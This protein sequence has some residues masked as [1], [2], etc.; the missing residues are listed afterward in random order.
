MGLPLV[1]IHGY[2]DSGDGFLHWR[3][4]L[5]KKQNLNPDTVHIVNYISL[6]NELTICD[7]AEGLEHALH[8]AGLATDAS[9]DAIV[10]STGM[11]VIRAWLARYS[12]MNRPRRLRH[13][14]AL[15]PATNGSP[16][17]HKGRSWLGALVKGSK[18][19]KGPDFLEAGDE[20]LHALELGSPFTW[21][22]AEKDL[23]GHGNTARFRK[24]PESPFV[25][26]FC[27]DADLGRVASLATQALGTKIEGSDGVVRWAGAALNS[28]RLIVDFTDS[29][30]SGAGAGLTTQSISP[31][32]NQDNILVL[33]P[34]LNHGTIM[35]PE[36]D[37]PLLDLVSEALDVNDDA[38]FTTWNDRAVQKADLER[39]SARAPAPWQ[40]FVIRV[41]DERGDGVTD[42]SIGLGIQ[43]K[44]ARSLRAVKVDDLH[45]CER[46]RSQRCLHVNLREA[47]LE[48]P[49]K[50]SEIRSFQMVL[51]MNTN[52]SYIIYQ[53]AQADG[54]E[55]LNDISRGTSELTI[56]L[57]RWLT[58]N[59]DGF[60][61][62]MPFTTTF[63]E[64]RVNREPSVRDGVIDICH[65]QPSAAGRSEVDP[66]N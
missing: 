39:G 26:T 9:F 14:V 34:G 44:G 18:N 38:G 30:D 23:F 29:S 35:K 55:F 19:W 51:Y 49:Q 12:S 40:Q 54:T 27:G 63:I 37:S 5:I 52:S 28:R 15:A 56:D 62:P 61:L 46:D 36:E 2:S 21:D 3:N 64:I 59:D 1:L 25:F 6:S 16:V 31:W 22:L 53:A 10:H 60:I 17:A 33:W 43:K 7:I 20:V 24:G 4:A 45:P 11:L 13:L 32:S 58:P 65:I 42:W 47:G 48:E 57:T 8:Q 66:G 50:R 41:V